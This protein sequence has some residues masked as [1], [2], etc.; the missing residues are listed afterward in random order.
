MVTSER[1]HATTARCFHPTTV[2]LLKNEVL[3]KPKR[4]TKLLLGTASVIMGLQPSR[5]HCSTRTST[6]FRSCAIRHSISFAD[7]PR[8]NNS[9]QSTNRLISQPIN[10]SN[11][12]IHAAISYGFLENVKRLHWSTKHRNKEN[13]ILNAQLTT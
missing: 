1:K 4:L 13:G 2:I 5:F 12:H 3:R 7:C 6:F 9:N 8:K 10:R 11:N